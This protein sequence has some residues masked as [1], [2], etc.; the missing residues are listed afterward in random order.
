MIKKINF[1]GAGNV[2]THLANKISKRIEI[3]TVFSKS[4]SNAEELASQVNS[5][6]VN[7]LTDLSVDVDLNIICLKDDAIENAVNFLPKDI[8]VVHT[9]GSIGINVFNSFSKYGILYPLQTFSKNSSLDVSSIPFLIEGN[10]NDYTN[11][12]LEFCK[13]NLS[14]HIHLA[15]SE[16]RKQIHLSAVISNNFLTALLRESEVILQQNDLDL[17]ILKPLLFETL[18]KSFDKN[19]LES[20]T[21]PAKRLDYNVINSHIQL[22]ENEKL[23]QLYQLLSDLIIEQQKT[24]L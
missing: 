17:S 16:L 24:I 22:L 15:D 8:P 20:Q 19:P 4:I 11:A 21:G 7:Q 10:S 5:I 13:N 1:I 3:K 14:A 18:K 6:G 2:A 23:K 9:S 12:L